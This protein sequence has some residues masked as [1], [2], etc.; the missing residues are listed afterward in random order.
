MSTSTMEYQQDRA[1]QAYVDQVV[2][3]HYL[4]MFE[5]GRTVVNDTVITR[6]L[7]YQNNEPGLHEYLDNLLKGVISPTQ[8]TTGVTELIKQA[9]FRLIKEALEAFPA[10][11]VEQAF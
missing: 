6:S 5:T 1:N 7:I 10:S 11:L 8:Y 3:G 9:S 4:E 2:W